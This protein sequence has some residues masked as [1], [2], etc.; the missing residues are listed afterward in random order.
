MHIIFKD[1]IIKNGKDRNRGEIMKKLKQNV[2]M[3]KTGQVILTTIAISLCILASGCAKD[4]KINNLVTNSPTATPSETAL[5]EATGGA[6]VTDAGVITGMATDIISKMTL[7]EKIGQLFVL[8][9][10]HLDTSKGSYFEY[11]KI[12]K[13]MIENLQKY[14]IGGVILFARNIETIEQ[15]KEL[16]N[17]LQDNT[18]V[19]LYISVDEE[20]G[21]VARIGSNANM[22]TSTFPP[23]E[24][25]GDS[26]DT[27]YAYTIG[28]T[29]GK[30]I[31]E[32]G[33][34]LN[35][36]PVADV[37]TS[38]LN[39]E[40][41]NRSFGSDQNMVASMV[42]QVINGLQS[43]NVSATLKHFPGQG[44]SSGDS[45]KGAVNIDDDIIK[46]RKID[47]VPFVEGVKAGADFIMVSHISISRVT[48]TT[49]PASLCSLVMNEMIRDELEFN[50]IIITD[51]MDM[52]AITEQYS[53][54]EAAVSTLEAGTDMVLMPE[55]LQEAYEAIKKAVENGTLSEKRIDTSLQRIMENKIKRGLILDNTDLIE[56]K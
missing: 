48:E 35:F 16:I 24:Q 25:V 6:I 3:K 39:T 56:L 10:E 11:R 8:N 52:K 1:E 50:G 17:D 38:D 23:M 30:E 44:N 13:K 33:F 20:G 49:K 31:K 2:P 5:P 34:N 28:E 53:S 46:M 54:A 45:H 21:N 19:P 14:H 51:A 22:R 7:E 18:K 41:G 43:Q 47:F 36:A 12:T 32:L 55:N 4:E 29:I 26:G 15:T 9:L 27:Q 40:I 37:R 42:T